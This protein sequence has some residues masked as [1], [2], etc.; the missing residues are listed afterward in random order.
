MANR[1]SQEVVEVLESPNATARLSQQVVEV[2]DSPNAN[3]RLSQEV[4]EVLIRA[5]TFVPQV[6]PVRR[7]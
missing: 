6:M 3:V 1:L 4:V 7:V 2:L 5:S